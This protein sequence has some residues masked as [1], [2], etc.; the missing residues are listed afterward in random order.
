MYL[1]NIRIY[2]IYLAKMPIFLSFSKITVSAAV[3]EFRR[4]SVSPILI[5]RPLS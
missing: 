2:F 4:Y 1:K 3:A 5:F